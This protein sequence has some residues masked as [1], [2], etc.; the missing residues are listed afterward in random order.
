MS[1]PD[2]MKYLVLWQ[3]PAGWAG[4]FAQP[5]QEFLMF[6]CLWGPCL[7][8]AAEYEI[9]RSINHNKNLSAAMGRS[10]PIPEGIHF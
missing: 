7:K 3:D 1:L 9:R 5:F 6:E 2:L 10:D 4:N 8:C